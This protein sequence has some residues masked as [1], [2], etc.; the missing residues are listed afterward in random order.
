[1]FTHHLVTCSLIFG[2]YGYHY[3]KVGNVILCIM[4]SV[5][6]TLAVRKHPY[7]RPL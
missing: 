4:D 2:S 7:S 1:M 6:S 5:D 3:V